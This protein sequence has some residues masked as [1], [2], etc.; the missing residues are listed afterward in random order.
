MTLTD[1]YK[2]SEKNIIISGISVL[3]ILMII[4][5]FLFTKKVKK[6]IAKKPIIGRIAII[7][8]DFG[9]NNRSCKFFELLNVPISASILPKLAYSE[10]TAN[11]AHRNNKEVML[12]LPLEPHKYSE[13]YP[14]NYVIETSMNKNQ[15]IR[16]L[17]ESFKSTPFAD[18]TNNHMGS[19]G[20]EDQALMKIILTYLK[21]QS[22]F[23]VDSFVSENSVCLE[24]SKKMDVPSIKRDIFLDNKNNRQ[25][26]ENQFLKLADI[27]RKKGYAVG[28]GHDRRLTQKIILEQTKLL[29]EQGFEF[30][31]IKEMLEYLKKKN[32]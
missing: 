25:Y 26:I 17:N 13:K 8:D 29:S 32:N 23:F 1:K 4:L 19:K 22:L 16:I 3:L 5:S 24:L 20:T 30:I 6:T 10:E 28:I 11:C 15:I 27:A 18:G 31:S 9:Y 2:F 21:K 14:D 12:H 7:V